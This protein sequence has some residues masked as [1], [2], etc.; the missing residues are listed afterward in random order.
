MGEDALDQA[1][2]FH[3]SDVAVLGDDVLEM[4]SRVG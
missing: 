1:P 4:L 3:R 2:T